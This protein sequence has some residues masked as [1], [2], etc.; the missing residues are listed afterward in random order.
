MRV[1]R[2]GA[3]ALAVLVTAGAL[4]VLRRRVFVVRVRGR[5][6]GPTYGDGDQLVMVRSAR[7]RRGDVVAFRLP[8]AAAGLAA[9]GRSGVPAV[10]RVAGVAGDAPA[11]DLVPPGHVF[12]VG[13]ARHSLDSRVY[14]PVP[15]DHL[16]GRA[17]R[18]RPC[19][20]HDG[21]AFGRGGH[22]ATGAAPPAE[23]V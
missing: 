21:G 12:L 11:G 1:V 13:D 6:M 20:G 4:A 7:V 9:V 16:L 8:A 19:G 15:V 2:A 3:A 5:S 10:K 18:P 17:V 23:R 14:G 22:G